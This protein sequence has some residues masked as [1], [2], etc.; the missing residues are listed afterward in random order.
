MSWTCPLCQL[1]LT[2]NTAQRQYRCANNHCFDI[3]KEGYC[4]LIPAQQKNSKNPGDS[5]AMIRARRLFLAAGYYDNLAQTVAN[6]VADIKPQ[7]ALHCLEVGCGEGYYL[8]QI[9]AQ[10]PDAHYYGIDISKEAIRLAAKGDSSKQ[11]QYAVASSYNI[12]LQKHSMDVIIRN[13]A[14]APSSQIM[15]LLKPG[16]L[17]IVVTPGAKHLYQLR[18]QIYRKPTLHDN[19]VTAVEGFDLVGQQRLQRTIH[20]QGLA[21]VSSLLQMTPYYWQTSET[22]KDTLNTLDELSCSTDFVVSLFRQQAP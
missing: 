22:D 2:L 14:P 20:I 15:R 6:I 18:Q 17:F 12:P 16:G 19:P 9:A 5:K 10:M 11:H 13:F 4:N 21:E 8:R 7:Q 1:S 3:A